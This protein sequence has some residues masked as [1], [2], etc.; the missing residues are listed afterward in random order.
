LT[1]AITNL[2]LKVIEMMFEPAIV[3]LVSPDYVF[4]ACPFCGKVHRHGNHIGE[5]NE[6]HYGTRVPH[7]EHG[8]RPKEDQY[9]LVSTPRTRRTEDK[10]EI[11]YF[12]D[13]KNAEE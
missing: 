4:V 3:L 6:P 7:C 12:L 10:A 8:M 9:F 1:I 5:L 2:A 13:L 11:Q